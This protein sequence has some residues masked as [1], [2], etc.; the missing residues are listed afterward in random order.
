MT[1]RGR[2]DPP[3]S[4]PPREKALRLLARREH[5]RRELERKLR[6]GGAPAPDAAATV[7]ALAAAALVD[8]QRFAAAL[9]RRRSQAGYG[10]RH[11]LAELA[12]HGIEA[13]RVADLLAE[14]DFTAIARRLL[15]RRLPARYPSAPE[16]ARAARFLLRR[17]FPADLVARLTRVG[18][19]DPG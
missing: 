3:A 16:R 18:G 6:A 9:V 5:S 11:I 13:T 17:G 14:V 15:D 19:S 7:E 10:P 4:H 12:E 2:R 8:D 1:V